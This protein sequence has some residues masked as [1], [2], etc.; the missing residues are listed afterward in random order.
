[1]FVPV[2][3]TPALINKVASDRCN[4][5]EKKAIFSKKIVYIDRTKIA[6]YVVLILLK[7]EMA[8][9]HD[10]HKTFV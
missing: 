9:S 2:C 5:F 6:K 10:A 1:M 4:F 8:C 3:L 7:P